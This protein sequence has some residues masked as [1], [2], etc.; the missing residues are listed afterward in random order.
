MKSTPPIA[1][2][3]AD[4]ASILLVDDNPRNLDALESILQ[5]PVHSLVRASSGDEALLALMKTE[6]AVIVLDIQMPN[7]SGL[8]LA[9][10]IKMRRRSQHIP[11][12]FLTA[13]FQDDKDVLEG[14]GV[15]AVDYLTK[16][17]NP[18]ILKSKIGV[19]VDLFRANRALA[20]ANAALESEILQRKEAEAALQ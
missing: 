19:F 14:Y 6:F 5:S 11:I 15:G 9:K 17:I 2:Q 13:H 16:P 7:M 20:L 18:L 12:L 10:L 3:D 8:E 1:P 4:P